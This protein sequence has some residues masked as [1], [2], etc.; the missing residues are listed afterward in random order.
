MES[1]TI[2]DQRRIALDGVYADATQTL[3]A[4]AQQLHDSARRFREAYAAGQDALQRARDELAV[5]DEDERPAAAA[6]VEALTAE[7]ALATSSLARLD[8]AAEDVERTRLFL[9]RVPSDDDAGSRAELAGATVDPSRQEA[10]QAL[11]VQVLEAQETERSRLAEDLHDGP[12]QALANALLQLQII[13]KSM[14]RDPA[15]TDAELRSLKALLERELNTV[16]EYI[17]RLRPTLLEDGP[18]EEALT[19]SRK[20]LE[21]A[22]IR[23]SLR[24][25]AP[26]ALLDEPRRTVVLRVAQEAL[27]N[28]RKH[29]E[30][31]AVAITTRVERRGERDAWILEVRD[32]GRGFDVAETLGRDSRRHFGLRFMRERA[33]LIGAHLEIEPERS[34]G[35]LVRLTIDDTERSH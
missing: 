35:T 13:E 22:G 4:S 12:A 7:M 8:L 27:R 2:G 11:R 28:A 34:A 26:E 10:G 30:A 20:E 15:G 33:D 24:L 32:D 31:H 14:E 25:D 29:A 3:G 23:V 21:A 1:G 9:E 17:S 19:E 16:R 18:L 5:A 6:R